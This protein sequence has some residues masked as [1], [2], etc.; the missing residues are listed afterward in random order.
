MN[1][2]IH[3]INKQCFKCT[4]PHTYYFH[5]KSM[6]LRDQI[7]FFCSYPLMWTTK[8]RLS[9]WPQKHDLLIISWTET[10]VILINKASNIS[11][12]LLIIFTTNQCAW[13]TKPCFS[14]LI[15]SGEPQIHFC[16]SSSSLKNMICWFFCKQNHST[17]KQSLFLRYQTMFKCPYPLKQTIKP[18]YTSTVK[19]M[20]FRNQ[21]STLSLH[22]LC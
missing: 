20:H 5:W 7:M 12:F 15:L 9:F 2:N 21:N 11:F 22:S 19:E 10:S 17:K 16:P 14:V 6:C 13:E 8:S 1:R 3:H 18:L 4:S